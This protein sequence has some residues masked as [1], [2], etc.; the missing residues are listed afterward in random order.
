MIG[1]REDRKNQSAVPENIDT[2][3]VTK[4]LYERLPK[5]QAK[6]SKIVDDALNANKTHLIEITGK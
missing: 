3:F 5:D 1:V 2:D 6:Y 4:V